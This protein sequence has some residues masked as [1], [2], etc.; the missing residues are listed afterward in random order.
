MKQ[1]VV[2]KSKDAKYPLVDGGRVCD[3]CLGQFFTCPKCGRIFRKDDYEKAMHLVPVIA[4]IALKIKICNI[5]NLHHFLICLLYTYF[6]GI[7][8]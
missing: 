5:Y 3:K 4:R 6:Y 2:C 7:I 8:K 1:C